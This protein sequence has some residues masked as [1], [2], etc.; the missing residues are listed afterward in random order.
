MHFKL[1]PWAK[2]DLDDLVTAANN[3]NIAKFMTDKFP[4]PYTK[5]AGEQFINFAMQGNP[6]NIFA[7][8]VAGKAV[9]GIGLLPMQDVESINAEMGYWLAEPYWGKGI[10][11]G[12]IQQIVDYGF[13]TFPIKT[14]FARPYAT[15]AGS[16]RVLEKAGFSL[17]ATLPQ[18]AFKNNE[19]LDLKIY[20]IRKG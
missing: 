19:L 12:A 6:V 9:G 1:R 14:I 3:N 7:I 17:A 13:K 20:T 5:E 15:N 2:S 4:H 18:W 11:T 10:I 16:Q 8:E